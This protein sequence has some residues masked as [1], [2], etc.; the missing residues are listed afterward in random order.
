MILIGNKML[1]CM[2]VFYRLNLYMSFSGHCDDMR[3]QV[4]V[5]HKKC[6]PNN[7]G[8]SCYHDQ[9]GNDEVHCDCIPQKQK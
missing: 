3:M 1:V 9:K 7:E 8:C 6:I 2:D 4:R 5:T